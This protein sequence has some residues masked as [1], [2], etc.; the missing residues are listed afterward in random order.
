MITHSFEMINWNITL[1]I[2][3]DLLLKSC[4]KEIS[5]YIPHGGKSSLL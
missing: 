5:I 4:L 1:K 3:G 2:D